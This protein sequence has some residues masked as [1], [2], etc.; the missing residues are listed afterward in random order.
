M[1]YRYETNDEARDFHKQR[2]AF[3]ILE[4]ILEFLPEGSSMS[5]FEYCQT[6]GLDKE[7]F[8]QIT[9]GFYLNGDAVFYKDNFVFDDNVIHEALKHIDEIA[10]VVHAEKIEI[11]FGELPDQGFIYDYHYGKYENGILIP[12]LEKE[13]E[14]T[15]NHEIE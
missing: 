15:D 4:G 14:K 11:Y 2:K 9:R 7:R 10:D 13:V 12:I 6:K 8:N 3:I 1:D 5:H